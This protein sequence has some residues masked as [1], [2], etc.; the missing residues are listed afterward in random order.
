[1]K[2]SVA[3]SGVPVSRQRNLNNANDEAILFGHYDWTL[4]ALSIALACTASYAA[5][6]LTARTAHSEGRS[7]TL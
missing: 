6:D 1:M 4:V 5:L 3:V 2:N 7:R